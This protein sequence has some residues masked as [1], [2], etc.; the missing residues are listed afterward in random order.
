MF[1]GGDI[2]RDGYGARVEEDKSTGHTRHAAGD[3]NHV[4]DDSVSRGDRRQVVEAD[5]VKE[6]ILT[7][8]EVFD[9]DFLE[10]HHQVLIAESLETRSP[11]RQAPCI[12]QRLDD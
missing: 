1:V 3:P 7:G 5:K 8:Y 9:C 11:A 6:A 12:S 10:F 4:L 2:D